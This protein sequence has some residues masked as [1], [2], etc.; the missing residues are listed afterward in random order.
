MQTKEVAALAREQYAPAR[1]PAMR[2]R[3]RKCIQE[4]VNKKNEKSKAEIEGKRHGHKESGPLEER[5]KEK[6]KN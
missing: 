1:A 3:A 2:K 4:H 6:K 5:E